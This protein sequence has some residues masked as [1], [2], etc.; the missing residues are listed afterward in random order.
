V[1]DPV[2]TAPA[3]PVTVDRGWEAAPTAAVVA[4]GSGVVQVLN[5]AA[6][7]LFPVPRP[8]VP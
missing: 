4:D 2:R 7:E 3:T 8:A 6:R 1:A 5:E